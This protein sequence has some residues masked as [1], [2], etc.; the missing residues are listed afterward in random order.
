MNDVSVVRRTTETRGIFNRQEVRLA[1]T[2]PCHLFIEAEPE[3]DDL[4]DVANEVV[5]IVRESV[6]LANDVRDTVSSGLQPSGVFQGLRKVADGREV[7]VLVV[8]GT[9]CQGET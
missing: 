4:K 6:E 3:C 1:D 5:Y 7:A 8:N 9:H 2:P